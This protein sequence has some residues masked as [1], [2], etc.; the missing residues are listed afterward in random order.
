MESPDKDILIPL[1][2]LAFEKRIDLVLSVSKQINSL[3]SMNH[4]HS[5]KNSFFI[6]FSI[7]LTPSCWQKI[8]VSS[9]YK[10]ER[11]SDNDQGKSFTY[12]RKRTG[13]PYFNVPASA[14][15]LSLQTKDFLFEK[16]NSNHLIIVSG[17]QNISFF[18][19]E[20]DCTKYQMLSEDLLILC[21]S[22]SVY[23]YQLKQS[24]SIEPDKSLVDGFF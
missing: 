20:L 8:H 13:T 1:K 21:R 4:W 18:Q 10:Q 12:N 23:P 9:A 19:V 14:K 22:A 24:L 5:D 17:N 16:Q 7:F 3:L 15:T 2:S 6:K 11:A